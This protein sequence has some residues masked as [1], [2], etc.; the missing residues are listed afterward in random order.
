VMSY[1]WSA[2]AVVE[3]DPMGSGPYRAVG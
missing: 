2:L 3:G 1:R